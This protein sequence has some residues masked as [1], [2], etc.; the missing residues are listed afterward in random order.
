MVI[1]F[2]LIMMMFMGA[3][4]WGLYYHAEALVN[5][6]AQDG[7]RR[8]ESQGSTTADG[9]RAARDTLGQATQNG[10]LANVTVAVT[11]VGPNVQAVVTG[12]V[13][14]LVPLPLPRTVRGVSVGPRERFIQE[15]TR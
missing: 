4:Q 2:P 1:L 5:A 14:M 13:P 10:A 11:V 3:V 9:E 12:D 6:A 8:A 7:A 15:G